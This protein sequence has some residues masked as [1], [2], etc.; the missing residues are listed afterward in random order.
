MNDLNDLISVA[1][2]P[3]THVTTRDTATPC[4][5]IAFQGSVLSL[6]GQAADA[7]HTITSGNHRMAVHGRNGFFALVVIMFGESICGTQQIRR[8]LAL[9]R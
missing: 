8:R 4:S 5:F 7:V 1:Q 2:Q 6:T 9:H 3:A